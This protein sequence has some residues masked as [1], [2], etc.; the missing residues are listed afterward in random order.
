MG[1]ALVIAN[2]DRAGD[3]V[4]A[5]GMLV[6]VAVVAGA[7]YGLVRLVGRSRPGRGPDA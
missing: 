5:L 3:H 1:L 7:V 2:L 4:A 6:G